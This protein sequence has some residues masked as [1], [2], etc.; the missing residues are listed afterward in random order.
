MANVRIIPSKINPLTKLP[1]NSLHKRRVAAY[2]RVST[3]QE[4]QA[5]SYEAQV[6]YYKNFIKNRP[7]WTLVD[8]YT[9]K[10][11]SGTNLK[12]RDGFNKMIADARAGL[13]DL[14]VTKSVS[15]FA[16]N[17]LDTISLTRELKAKGVEIFFEEQNVYTFDSNGELML[18]ILAS[19]AQEE[20]RNIS[21]NVKWGKKKKAVDG[22]SQVGYSNFLGYDK[23]ENAKIGLKVNEEQA[24][25]VRFIYREFLKGKSVNTICHMLEERGIET[26]GHKDHWR[27]TTVTSILKN[28]KYKGDC[29]MQKTYVKNFLDHVAVKNKG[30][31]E[32]IYVEDHHE[33]I[34]SKDH[35]LMV[36]LEFERRGSLAQGFNSCNEFS[37]KLVCGD[38]GSYYGAKVLH[39]T[40]KYRCVKYRC[41]R[42]Y[43]HDHICQTPF[44]TEEE[45]K[46]KFILAYNE[47]IGNRSQLV[48][49]CKEMIQIL[50]NT[51]ELETKLAFLNQKAEDIII[52]V[53]NLIDQNST[54]ALDQDEFQKKYDSYDL[55][56]KKV[57]N[58]IEQVGLE[59]EKKNAQAKYLQA[60]IDDLENRPNVL[61][62]YDEDIWSY[63]IDKAVVNRDRS[64]TFNFRNGKE[65]KIN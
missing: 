41:N 8:I 7:E 38:C 56:H 34:V 62:A 53:K 25:V 9:D 28:E 42:K 39:S 27:T 22:Y 46:S 55:E 37:C 36:Q 16:R 10:G 50:D 51:S 48:E 15:R 5:N 13:I 54:E 32:K 33:P 26:P 45:V 65:I 21:E 49:D 64:I 60:F 61:E 59:I 35:W 31:L 57:I 2:A 44:V 11:I 24:E 14:I 40:D 29:E 1:N 20:S 23:H 63:L 52:L 30:E 6:D 47:F 43:N 19:M 18:T 17:T 58:E 12:H 3:E 4:E